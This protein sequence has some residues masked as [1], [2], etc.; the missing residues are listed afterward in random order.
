MKISS[1]TKKQTTTL[2]LLPSDPPTSNPLS[3]NLPNNPLSISIL[4]LVAM[5]SSN[6]VKVLDHLS[7]KTT[8]LSA[9]L[10]Y[11]L[12]WWVII[13]FWRVTVNVSCLAVNI[14]SAEAKLTASQLTLTVT[15]QKKSK[16]NPSGRRSE[17]SIAMMQYN[18]AQKD[19]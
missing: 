10:R 15:V 18:S 14:G 6:V 3:D 19:W 16:L 7:H 5:V 9:L 1:R 4:P 8:L 2:A 17:R 12:Q 11:L 13:S